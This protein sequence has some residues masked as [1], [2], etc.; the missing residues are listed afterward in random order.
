MTPEELR[1]ELK[2]ADKFCSD[3]GLPPCPGIAM[4]IERPRPPSGYKV[5]TPFGNCE[6]LNCQE[7]GGRFVT[8]FR[9]SR[10]QIIAYLKKCGIAATT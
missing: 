5:K 7:K 6:I 3:E 9:V 2:K 10:A 8:C 1:D 4:T